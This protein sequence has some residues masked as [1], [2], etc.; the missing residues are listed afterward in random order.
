MKK[1]FVS[2]QQLS[3]LPD[4]IWKAEETDATHEL[5]NYLWDKFEKKDFK[6]MH[7]MIVG[8]GGSY[9]AAL[10]AAHSIRDEMRT[11]YVDVFTPQ[12]A[13]RT[14]NQ[15]D[16]ILDCTWYPE[17]DVIIGISYSGKTPDIKAISKACTREGY[18][19]I[20]LTGAD[21]SELK[22]LYYNYELFKV[23]SYFNETDTSGKEKGMISMFS[24]LMP[25]IVFDD[26]IISSARPALHYF[27]EYQEELK[28]GKKFVSKLNITDIANSINKTPVV[29]V[30]YEW[31]TLPTAADIESKFVK[32]GI[33][34]VVLHEK[35]NFSHGRYTALYNQNFALVI[36]LTYYQL[37]ILMETSEALML[38]RHD[39]DSLIAEFLKGL[40]EN[41]SAHYIEMGNS[42][43]DPAQWNIREM[44]KLPYLITEIGEK[45]NIDISKPLTPF[46][47]EAKAL[48][49]YKDEF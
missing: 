17:Y 36:N 21:K 29:H 32:S 30:F 15:F 25:A 38:Y 10:V 6:P 47:E 26:Y 19:F 33:A 13:L 11:P 44:S 5:Y 43:F 2:R 34:N 20:L 16:K 46:P 28:N 42:L 40:C 48:Y 22:D 41:K 14:L 3:L 18:P 27:K 39:Y 1:N 45:L 49:D 9:P 35:K 23:I 12:T 4:R 31:E 37:G 8:S 7:I 24:T